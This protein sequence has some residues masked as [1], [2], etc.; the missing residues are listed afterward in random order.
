LGTTGISRVLWR[1]RI[2]AF[3]HYDAAIALREEG[4]LLDLSFVLKSLALWPF[5]W[6][7]MPRRYKIAAVMI[8]QHWS[9]R[10]FGGLSKH[11]NT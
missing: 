9:S 3:N 4:S 6:S 10:F 1:R 7:D 2:S 5:P 11:G 8:K